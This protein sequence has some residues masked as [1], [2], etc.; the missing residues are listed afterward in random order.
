M[1]TKLSM[2]D[3][4]Q[5]VL[6]LVQPLSKVLQ[7]NALILPA[8]ITCCVKTLKTVKK[9]DLLLTEGSDALK[10]PEIFP[11]TVALINQFS[12]KPAN[13]YPEHQ[14][15]N[16]TQL[17]PGRKLFPILQGKLFGRWGSTGSNLKIR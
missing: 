9:M 4:K 17:N 1:L 15:R 12:P 11:N 14:T 13:V 6:A 16:D 8:L 5:D 2:L 7:E 3:V 10:R